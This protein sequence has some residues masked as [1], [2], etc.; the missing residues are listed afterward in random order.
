MDAFTDEVRTFTPAAI[1]EVSTNYAMDSGTLIIDLTDVDWEGEEIE[2]D[3]ELGAGQI[4]IELPQDVGAVI[5]AR[6]GVGQV[7]VFGRSSEGLG[8]GRSVTVDGLDGAGEIT[9]TVRVGAGQITVSQET[10]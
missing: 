2:I 3:A 4:E 10:N 1:E 6:A 9:M 5:N 8:V 7:N